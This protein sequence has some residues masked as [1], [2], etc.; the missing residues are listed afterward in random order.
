MRLPAEMTAC[1]AAGAES[2]AWAVPSDSSRARAPGV[3]VRGALAPARAEGAVPPVSA[4]PA[5]AGTGCQPAPRA[6]AAM[7]TPRRLASNERPVNPNPSLS[8]P[9][10]LAAGLARKEIA[11][12]RH[13][14]GDSPPAADAAYLGPPL[15]DARCARDSAVGPYQRGSVAQGTE[16]RTAAGGWPRPYGPPPGPRVGGSAARVR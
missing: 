9:A 10:G 5:A 11:L 6:Q 15:A 7:A 14:D 12:R 1:T 8:A 4:E 16:A 13:S 3:L 2:G